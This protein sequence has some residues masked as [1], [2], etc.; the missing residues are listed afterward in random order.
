M[1]FSWHH[2][3]LNEPTLSVSVVLARIRCR[4]SPN[5]EIDYRFARERWDVDRS[6]TLHFE[7]P[8][9]S[10]H[11]TVHSMLCEMWAAQLEHGLERLQYIVPSLAVRTLTTTM[12]RRARFEHLHSTLRRR[13]KALTSAWFARSFVAQQISRDPS[14]MAAK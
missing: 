11:I 6:H 3:L 12:V 4:R 1:I 13:R 8:S 10:D 7:N 5:E 2:S 9:S 14:K